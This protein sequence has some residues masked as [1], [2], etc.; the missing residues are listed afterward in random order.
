MKLKTSC[1]DDTGVSFT[2]F[3]YQ[4]HISFHVYIDVLIPELGGVYMTPE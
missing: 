3:P 4:T 1:L 2:V